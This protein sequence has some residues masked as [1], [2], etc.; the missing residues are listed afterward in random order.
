MNTNKQVVAMVMLMALG[1]ASLLAYTWFD[2]GRR[3]EAE[4]QQ[5]IE[6]AERGA[7]L[8][9]A[10]CRFCHG[11]V[12]LGR[13]QHPSLIGPALNTPDNTAAYRESDASPREQL[14]ARYFDTISCGRNGTAMPPWAVD[15]GGSLVDSKIENLAF[16][17]TTNAGNAWE[18]AL[19]LAAESD[20]TAIRGLRQ[21]LRDAEAG[22][23]QDAIAAART[24][25][26]AAEERFDAGLP[27]PVPSPALTDSSCGQRSVAAEAPAPA[28]VPAVDTSAFTAD[29]ER[30][31]DLFFANGCNVCHGDTGQ[32][33]I[34]PR[35]AGTSLTFAQEVSQYRNPRDAMPAISEQ[36]VPDEDVFDIYSWLQTLE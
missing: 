3:A 4:D 31:S 1:V 12:G 25:L 23:G 2:V 15:Q 28:D 26:E 6:S 17:I 36:Q 27:V 19:E 32:G 22:G 8:F 11:N 7:R 10:N 13:V 30:G 20:E 24:A 34:G 18:V 33:G 21:A 35:I 14:A 16:L 9:A 5:A 29:V